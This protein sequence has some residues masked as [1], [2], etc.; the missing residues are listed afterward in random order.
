MAT[1]TP[2]TVSSSGTVLTLA[3]AS[4]GG[5]TIANALGATFIVRN[6][7]A[8]SHSFT[9]V[10]QNAC[11]MGS[12]TPTHDLTVAVAAGAQEAIVIG[13]KYVDSSGNAHVTYTAVTSVTVGATT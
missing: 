5:D 8:S 4:G 12:N 6:G 10:Q 2:Q 7:D 13:G 3:A 9:L 1:I 11:D